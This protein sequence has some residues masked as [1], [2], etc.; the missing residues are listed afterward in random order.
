MSCFWGHKFNKW[1]I[2]SEKNIVR[3]SL[4]ANDKEQVI[5]EAVIQRRKCDNC[6][7]TQIDRQEHR[8]FS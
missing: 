1:K 7:F 8:V 4:D 3:G 2:V 5:G 6:G